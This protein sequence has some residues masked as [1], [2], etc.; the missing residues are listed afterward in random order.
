M[1][2]ER[3]EN[4]PLRVPRRIWHGCAMAALSVLL[5]QLTLILPGVMDA[6]YS[7]VFNIIMVSTVPIGAGFACVA[8]SVALIAMGCIDYA[9][10]PRS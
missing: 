4:A 2:S 7:G 3:P 1:S 5:F 8:Y 6:P 9:R 10:A